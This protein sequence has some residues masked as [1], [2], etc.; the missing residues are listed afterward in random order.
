MPEI[1]LNKEKIEEL[2]AR[3]EG[4][5]SAYIVA[6]QYTE[7]AQNLK[8]DMNSHG[9]V[10]KAFTKKT[11]R[12]KKDFK[13]IIESF[14]SADQKMKE[15]AE[16][17][18]GPQYVNVN[19]GSTVVHDENGNVI[20][21]R[22][23]YS[24]AVQQYIHSNMQHLMSINS[25]NYSSILGRNGDWCDAYVDYI[26]RMSGMHS[27][28]AT[29]QE[30]TTIFEQLGL[31][32]GLKYDNGSWDEFNS[33]YGSH[34]S[35]DGYEPKTGDLVWASH[36]VTTGHVGIY[37]V[38]PDDGC[39]YIIEGNTPDTSMTPAQSFYDR[40]RHISFGDMSTYNQMVNSGQL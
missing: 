26:I 22:E 33:I 30:T 18:V 29:N 17:I 21:V 6:A 19:N 7:K 39:A 31:R 3:F 32:H 15:K 11:E 28:G 40:Y 35:N 36:G 8:H 2:N 9:E 24:Y 27:P 14:T 5:S 12:I 10:V 34:V 20:E 38:N 13:L 16:T 1:L 25:S 23:G 4:V 37:Y